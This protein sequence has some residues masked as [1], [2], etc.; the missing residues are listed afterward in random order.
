MNKILIDYIQNHLL[1]GKDVQIDAGDDLF[2][3]GLVDSMG[4]MSLISFIENRF[5]LSVPPEDMTGENFMTVDAISNY[6]HR[7]KGFKKDKIQ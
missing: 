6:L 7:H 1:G 2:E 3:N 4:M 5:E